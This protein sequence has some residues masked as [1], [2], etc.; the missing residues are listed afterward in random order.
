M[1]PHPHI[2]LSTLTYLFEGAIMHRDSIGSE[3]EIMPGAVN[4]MMSAGG[5]C[6]PNGLPKDEGHPNTA[7]QHADMG[8]TAYG[9]GGDGALLHTHPRE[10]ISHLGER[11][12]MKLIA[13]EAFRQKSPVP[14][15]S[16]LYLIVH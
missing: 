14:V 1:P 5:W 10:E 16:P 2:G 7:P 15:H 3:V 9:A 11:I 13:G 8:G 12:A 6:T 4:W